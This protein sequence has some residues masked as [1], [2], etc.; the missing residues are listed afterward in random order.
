MNAAPACANRG[1]IAA[2]VA[3]IATILAIYS[4]DAYGQSLSS[5]IASPGEVVI[6]P[7]TLISLGYEWRLAGDE[8]RN[9]VVDVRFRE[10][11]RIEWQIGL[12]PLRLQREVIRNPPFDVVAPNMFAGSLFDLEADT[13][14]EIKLTLKDQDGVRGK[15]ERTVM[16][17][18]RA[19]PQ[20]ARVGNTFHVYPPDYKGDKRQPAFNSLLAAYYTGSAHADWS[21]A[22]PPRVQ[23]GDVILVHAGTYKDDRHRYGGGMGTVFDGTY[24]LTAS[25]TADMPIVVKS[26]GDGEV[27]FD[28]DGNYN[29][30]NVMS[31]NHNYFEGLTV[32]NTEVAFLAGQ[33]NIAGAIGFTLKHSKLE[34]VGIGVMT[35][36]SGSKNFYIADNIFVGRQNPDRLLGWTGRKW[37]G[38]DGFPQ[39]LHSNF[40]VKVYGSGHVIAF[41]SIANFHDGIDHATY[42]NPDRYPNTPRDRMPVSIDIYNNDVFNVDDNCIEVDGALY[43]VRVLRNRCFNHGHRA[44][45]AQPLFGGPAYFIRNIVYHAPE[46]GSIKLHANP[47]GVLF[48]HNTLIGEV[49]EMGPASNVHF[50]NNLILGQG[51]YPEVFSI[52]TM[53]RYSSSDYNGFATNAGAP[54][55]FAWSEPAAVADYSGPRGVQRF[56]SLQEY[57][58]ATG[59]DRHSIVVDFDA[60]NNVMRPNAQRIDRLYKPDDFDFRLR[61][62]SPAI[63]A[64]T[65][66]PNVNDGFSG[67][68]PDLGAYE[69][70]APTTL[71]GPRVERDCNC[72][73]SH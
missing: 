59:Q 41:N 26:A 6:E 68:A 7:P 44:L 60:F 66:L 32:R 43:N 35:D 58:T 62:R 14:Y 36:W 27:I 49:H 8:N 20:P 72:K 1:T 18:T 42:G 45:S 40:A 50:R 21:N 52:E 24:Y 69:Y 31:A 53:T 30:F 54:F 37:A 13:E 61:E 17:R 71:Y 23:P 63:D 22:F 51:A 39:P 15:V 28:G 48:Y 33:K 10:R 73:A 2:L 55:S 16:A 4:F 47:S 38:I 5:N 57:A 25:G 19:E 70:G 46:G 56:K 29:L 34:N 64:G 3:L 12:P 9:A 11:G 67:K 65:V